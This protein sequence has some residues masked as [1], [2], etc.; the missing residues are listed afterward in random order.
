[1]TEVGVYY[2]LVALEGAL[3]VA[4]AASLTLISAPYG[5]HTRAGWGPALPVRLAWV[6]MESPAVFAFTLAFAIG[7]RAGE[8][9][10]L[11][12]AAMWLC[13]Y[14]HRTFIYPFVMRE[15]S[16]RTMPLLIVA[17]GFT[18]NMLN[19]YVNGRWLSR[20]GETYGASWLAGAPFLAG[21]ALFWAGFAM[22]RWA[23][24]VLRRLRSPGVGV[25]PNETGEPR[26]AVPRG[27][28][29][30]L[31]SCPNYLGEV[32]EWTGWAIAT[33]SPAGLAFAVFT[34]AN[35]APRALS[36][37]RWY[38]AT[39]PDYPPERKAMIPFVL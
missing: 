29:Y 31:V 36:H 28:L 30:E 15:G 20:F 22:N 26:Y 2:A 32:L 10:P 37:H 25:S 6:L 34:A 21:A 8:L 23:D 3:A 17:M 24:R 5:R 9:V 12:L 19:G 11:I 38:R 7:P 13:H 14:L 1:M 4:T 18:F 16:A 39:F 33:W 35:L 27:G